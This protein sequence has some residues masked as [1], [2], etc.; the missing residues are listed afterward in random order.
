MISQRVLDHEPEP[1]FFREHRAQ[2]ILPWRKYMAVILEKKYLKGKCYWY[3]AEKKRIH[4][5][6]KRIFQKYLGPQEQCLARLLGNEPSRMPPEVCKYGAVMALLHVAQELGIV[7]LIDQYMRQQ[8]DKD[9]H[10]YHPNNPHLPSL[11]TYI[12]LAAI[13]RCISSTSKRDMYHWFATTSLKR[14]WP[15]VTPHT[16]SSQCFWDA[17]QTFQEHHLSELT[18]LITDRVFQIHADIDR[19]CLLFDQTNYYT[20]IDTFNQRNTLA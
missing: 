10:F 19:S 7:D 4:G 14:H 5:K 6:V 2:N 8:P 15:H 9:I 20:F 3:A 16:I 18:H 12:L 1:M 13:N 17:M 11:G